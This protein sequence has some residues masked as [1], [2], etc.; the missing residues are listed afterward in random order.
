MQATP[1]SPRYRLWVTL[2]LLAVFAIYA[3]SLGNQ[4]ALDDGIV[5]RATL[6]GGATN[7]MTATFRPLTDYFT[8]GYWI[9]NGGELS[10]LYR[11]VTILSYAATNALTGGVQADPEW[12]AFP[13]HLINVLLHV[14]ATWLA[15]RMLMP[16]V[17]QYW[18]AV[19]GA[20][21][22]GLHAIH[23]EVVAGIVGRAEL[24]GFCFGASALL[25][26]LRGRNG[27][28][29]ARIAGLA[30][31]GLLLFLAFGSKENAIAWAA[32][33]PVYALVHDRIRNNAGNP[34][35]TCLQVTLV[36][37][38]PLV[39]FL[40]LRHLALS[41][42]PSPFPVHRLANP[43]YDAPLATR[44]ITG[45]SIWGFGLYKCLLPLGLVSDYGPCTFDILDSLLAPA[46]VASAAALLGLLGC[47]IASLRRQ[48]LLFLAAACFLGF[49][50]S[51]SN[52]PL[53]IGTVFGERL[54]FTP[55]FGI[56]ILACW[57]AGLVSRPALILI[58][59]IGWLLMC[60]VVIVDRNSAWHDETSRFVQDAQ[61]NPRCLR[62]T[63]AYAGHLDRR[64][65]VVDA[66]NLWRRALELDPEF[67]DALSSLGGFLARAGRYNDAEQMFLRALRA[68]PG[69][70]PLRHITH[71]NLALLYNLLK[72]AEKSQ[73]HLRLAW[74]ENSAFQFLHEPLLTRTQ[75]QLPPDEVEKILA[76]G[77]QRVPN[78]PTW[79]LQHAY[80]AI[81]RDDIEAGL[82][83]L[84]RALALR[85]THD[86]T[87]WVLAAT[88]LQSG[89]TEAARPLLDALRQDK[90]ASQE[91]RKMAR[92]ALRQIK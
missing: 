86:Q 57:I 77:Q 33:L 53:A 63:E 21:V 37:L 12:E 54:Y 66:E 30:G 71:Y 42:V 31:S 82:G 22:F 9:G 40:A 84:R 14:F 11:P 60:S 83:H 58:P 88:L 20:A 16:I 38:V 34:L 92:E 2:I 36:A 23:S 73:Q 13:H 43:L 19:L 7:Q 4:F 45:I 5:A 74:R 75:A 8:N 6:P 41:E 61:R 28:G 67:V 68:P 17:T 70:K 76:T 62:L 25:L 3:P 87:R 46:F 78:H 72:Q 65:R 55:S 27:A 1:A 49:S 47:G 44:W 79:P 90:S 48:P 64:N 24:L 81:A 89:D 91:I 26:F 10:R 69:A 18:T 50:F 51:T 56:A 29:A 80:L 32:F 59:T 15:L 35:R 39:L 52:L 85:P